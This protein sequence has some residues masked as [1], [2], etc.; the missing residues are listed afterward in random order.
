MVYA[1]IICEKD[2]AASPTTDSSAG[3]A[4]TKTTGQVTTQ[5]NNPTT[6][7]VTSYT[8]VQEDEAIRAG[9]DIVVGHE[10]FVVLD[11]SKEK[12]TVAYK[13]APVTGNSIVIPDTVTIGDTEYKVVSIAD[14]AFKGNKNVTSITIPASVNKIGNNVFKG[15]KKLKKIIVKTKK[16]NT[17]NVTKNAFKGISKKTVI[18]VPKSKKKAYIKLFRKKGLSKK[19]KFK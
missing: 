11:D 10:V 3:S 12:P 2:S 8:Y 16:L 14:G 7:P 18:K 15:C 5:T 4:T 17:K 19:V 1:T 6:T 9:E 13:E